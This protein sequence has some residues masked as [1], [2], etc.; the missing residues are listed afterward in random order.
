MS[1]NDIH[2]QEAKKQALLDMKAS[3]VK[4]G[5]FSKVYSL[6][7][8]LGPTLGVEPLTYNSLYVR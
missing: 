1:K 2:K 7:E 5:V 8:L 3:K 6:K 4:I